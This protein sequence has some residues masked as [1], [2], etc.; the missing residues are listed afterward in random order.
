[1]Y[2][3]LVLTGSHPADADDIA[4][5]SFLRLFKS[6][7]T[8]ER[9]ARPKQWLV[10]VAHNLRHDQWQ[11]AARTAEASKEFIARQENTQ[12][13]TAIHEERLAVV[14]RAM[15]RLTSRQRTYLHLRAEGLRLKEIA[16][17]HGVT[18]Q[19]VAETCARAVETLGKL[20]NE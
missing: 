14:L 8:G 3:Y 9:I 10:S 12:E 15:M 13:E 7:C 17:I 20:S 16:E 11:K 4:Q 6:L 19:S 18:L 1:L 2:R 5:E